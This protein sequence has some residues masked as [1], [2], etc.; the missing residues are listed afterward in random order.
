[1][2][3]WS[4]SS[5]RAICLNFDLSGTDDDLSFRS[6]RCWPFC[7]LFIIRGIIRGLIYGMV[8]CSSLVSY[9]S[10]SPETFDK[11]L[12]KE[13]AKSLEIARQDL[14]EITFWNM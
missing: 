12:A 6:H 7:Y 10:R 1:M 3:I 9:R 14:R 4:I 8:F 5:V 13:N 2:L 11:K